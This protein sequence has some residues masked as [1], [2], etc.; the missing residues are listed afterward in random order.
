M[1]VHPPSCAGGVVMPHAQEF[2]GAVING[3]SL[4]TTYAD[5]RAFLPRCPSSAPLCSRS[6]PPPPS[7]PVW[8]TP[9]T[10]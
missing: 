2:R 10:V 3:S 5:M 6:I 7:C 1:L 4:I 8:R 9:R